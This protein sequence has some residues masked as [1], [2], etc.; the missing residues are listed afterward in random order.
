MIARP[1]WVPSEKDLA[2]LAQETA[3]VSEGGLWVLQLPGE[4]TPQLI[5]RLR[6]SQK[7]FCLMNLEYRPTAAAQSTLK[8]FA[9]AGWTEAPEMKDDGGPTTN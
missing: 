1:E 9:K 4:N 7:R 6:P 2:M 3:R 5:F 8:V